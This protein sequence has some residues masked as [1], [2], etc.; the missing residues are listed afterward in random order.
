MI[1]KPFE[2]GCACKT[3]VVGSASGNASYSTL[4]GQYKVVDLTRIESNYCISDAKQ[5]A[6][7]KQTSGELF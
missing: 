4:N 1:A 7:V 5:L 2:T 6:K 3:A